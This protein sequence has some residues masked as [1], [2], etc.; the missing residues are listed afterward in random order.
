M[1]GDKVTRRSF[2]VGFFSGFEFPKHQ[3]ASISRNLLDILAKISCFFFV[4]LAYMQQYA[5]MT[6]SYYKKIIYHVSTPCDQNPVCSILEIIL[7]SYMGIIMSY[8]IIWIPIDQPVFHGMPQPCWPPHCH[9]WCP[10]FIRILPFLKWVKLGQVNWYQLM[11]PNMEKQL[12]AAK[13]LSSDI[14]TKIST[15]YFGCRPVSRW[16]SA[17]LS[18]SGEG[19]LLANCYLGGRWLIPFVSTW[20]LLQFVHMDLGCNVT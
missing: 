8:S 10:V 5:Y 13:N 15:I 3:V 20:S 12:G 9:T 6:C 2:F 4:A 14:S 17:A 19:F 11:H 7:P 18:K 1:I 16:L